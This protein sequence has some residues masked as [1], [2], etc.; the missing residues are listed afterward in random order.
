MGSATREALGAATA[1][2]NAQGAV[3][4][5]TGEQLLAAA[6]VV[7]GS[8]ALRSALADDTAPLTNRASIVSAVFGAYSPAAKAV[9]EALSSGRWSSE[10]DFVSGIERLGIRAIASSAPDGVSIGD[11]LFEFSTAVSSNPELELALGSRLGSVEGKVALVEDL[12]GGKASEQTVAILSSLIAR[13]QGRRI[14]AMIRY[15]AS[16]VAEQAGHSIATVT[17]AA[18]LSAAQAENLAKALAVQYGNTIRINQ[19]VDPSIL[20]GMRVQIGDE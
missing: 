16:V 15:A 3:D 2:L 4:F 8:S 6:L 7:D 14:A 20:G 13:P 19:L 12:L 10:A 1:A 11:E 5:A 17:V 18:P 9:L